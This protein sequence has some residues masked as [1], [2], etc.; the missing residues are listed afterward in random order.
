MGSL[1]FRGGIPVSKLVNLPLRVLEGEPGKPLKIYWQRRWVRVTMIL[2]RWY[3]VGKWWEGEAVKLFYRLQLE[4]NRVWEVFF[5][6]EQKSWNL[7]K[8]YD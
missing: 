5:D 6:Q 3:D 2:D 7:Y 4:G 1:A 8:I